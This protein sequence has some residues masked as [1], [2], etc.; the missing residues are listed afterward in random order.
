MGDVFRYTL[1]SYIIPQK[2]EQIH[3]EKHIL[4]LEKVTVCLF[5]CWLQHVYEIHIL[6]YSVC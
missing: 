1:Q 5:V 3:P 2:N 4:F 6:L